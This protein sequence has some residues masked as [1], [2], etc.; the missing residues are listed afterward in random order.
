MPLPYGA[1]EIRVTATVARRIRMRTM[2]PCSQFEALLAAELSGELDANSRAELEAH[3]ATCLACAKGAAS[4][5][6][7][8]SALDDWVVE[9]PE[10]AHQEAIVEVVRADLSRRLGTSTVFGAFALGVGAAVLSALAVHSRTPLVGGPSLLA[11]G[12]IWAGVYSLAFYMV[13]SRRPGFGAPMALY[14]AGA[15]MVITM[16]LPLG[17]STPVCPSWPCF[18]C[19][20]GAGKMVFF[21][22][23][24][25][26]GLIPTLFGWLVGG[27]KGAGK[28]AALGTVGLIVAL[29]LPLIYLHC[30]P[31][32]TGAL[33][34]TAAGAVLGTGVIGAVNHWR[35]ARA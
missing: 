23:G 30:L 15:L 5:A 7:T 19:V 18:S 14:A 24:L 25:L 31:F 27:R 1:F 8:W 34:T 4:L 20:S 12:A 3:K 11:V 32:T 33:L 16:A 35:L 6:E 29:E 13:L 9:P 17:H 10:I 21:V 26:Y 28:Q 22:P 2:Q